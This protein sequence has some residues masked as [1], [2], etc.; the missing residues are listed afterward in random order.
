MDRYE[1]DSFDYY[2]HLDAKNR[3]IYSN[4]NWLNLTS[5]EVKIKI[6]ELFGNDVRY[7]FVSQKYLFKN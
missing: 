7:N 1:N 6:S 2:I 5:D 3:L 4:T